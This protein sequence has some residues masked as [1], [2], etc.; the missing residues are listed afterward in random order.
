M[1]TSVN[2]PSLLATKPWLMVLVTNFDVA[3]EGAANV[4]D[5]HSCAQLCYR[6]SKSYGEKNVSQTDRSRGGSVTGGDGM[7][8]YVSTCWS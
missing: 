8:L 4:R 6:M 2:G 3:E 5:L 1:K 7:E